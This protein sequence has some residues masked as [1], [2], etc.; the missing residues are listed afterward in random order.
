MSC[1]T[2]KSNAPIVEIGDTHLTVGDFSRLPTHCKFIA[3]M[4]QWDFLDFLAGEAKTLPNFHLLMETEAKDLMAQKAA[5]LG[6]SGQRT[7]G[8]HVQIRA[9]LTVAADGRHSILRA[10]SGLEVEDLGAPFDVLW[11]R[12]PQ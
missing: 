3:L 8:G 7:P 10:K 2:R 4:P 11:L 6:R 12:L 5:H 1:R 9:G